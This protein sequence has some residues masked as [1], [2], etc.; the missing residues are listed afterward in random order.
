MEHTCNKKKQPQSA[1]ERKYLQWKRQKEKDPHFQKK[2]NKQL[3]LLRDANRSKLS[4]SKLNE[5]RKK[6][7]MRQRMCRKKKKKEQADN[8]KE[9]SF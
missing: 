7:Q 8:K 4:G 3:G 1:A 5:L 6:E 2:A 9:I